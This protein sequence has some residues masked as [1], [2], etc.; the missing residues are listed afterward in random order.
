M[1]K[2]APVLNLKVE[3]KRVSFLTRPNSSNLDKYRKIYGEKKTEGIQKK[4]F[5]K[6]CLN[7]EFYDNQRTREFMRFLVLWNPSR[8]I[9]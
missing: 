7:P 8:S 4:N 1:A 5:K 9:C 2:L 6:G 3:E